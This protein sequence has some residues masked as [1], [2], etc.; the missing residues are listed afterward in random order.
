MKAIIIDDEL[1]ALHRMK[2]LLDDFSEIEVAGAF[3][4]PLEA[5]EWI[6]QEQID[7]VFLDIEMAEMSG[8]ELG[9]ELLQ[10]QPDLHIVFVTAYN[11]Y[12]VEA[13]EL[14]ALDY[15]LKPVQK[16][17][18]RK[19]LERLTSLN[20]NKKRPQK[21]GQG[22]LCLLQYISFKHPEHGSQLISW[23]TAKA[24][25]LFA[26][27][28]HYRHKPVHK[29]EILELLWPDTLPEKASA[30]LHT[31]I[32]QIRRALQAHGINLSI[33]YKDEGY[34]VEAGELLFDV[35]E[36]EK[37][38]RYAPPISQETL[39]QHK[40]LL[41]LYRGDYLKELPYIWIE[42]EQERLR[43]IWLEHVKKLIAYHVGREKYNEAILY[44]TQIKEKQPYQEEGYFGL[45]KMNAL[46]GNQGEVRKNFEQLLFRFQDDLGVQPRKE[47]LDW[48]KKWSASIE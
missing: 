32:Y 44:Y 28:M 17:R 7:I 2:K 3:H 27:L 43:T 47:V 14:N 37:G 46:L 20:L 35:E 16:E 9:E 21:N 30:L 23:R 8:M 15:V 42:A 11:H 45:M 48:Y 10:H 19:T 41:A 34:V 4:N 33:R 12:A 25:E 31:T 13:F 36:W 18:L 26:Y 24:Q 40:D 29:E 1:L 6:Q 5:L 39:K 22:M 38:I